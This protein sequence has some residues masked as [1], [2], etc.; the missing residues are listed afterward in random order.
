MSPDNLAKNRIEK[1]KYLQSISET[2]VHTLGSRFKRLTDLLFS[3]AQDLYS[4]RGLKVKPAWIAFL[5]TLKHSESLDIKRLANRRRISHSAA[6]QIIKEMEKAGF[7]TSKVEEKDQRQRKIEITELGTNAIEELVPQLQIIE[8][9]FKEILGEDF[10]IF[11][12]ILERFEYELNE[13][14]LIGRRLSP[15][16][17]IEVVKYEEKFSEALKYLIGSW[18]NKYFSI[19]SRDEALLNNPKKEILENGG[20]I[21]VALHE[22][23]ACGVLILVHHN[24]ETIELSKI[25]ADESL[26]GRG[27]GSALLKHALDYSKSKSYKEVIVETDSS[28]QASIDLF[29][30]FGFRDDTIK[31]HSYDN[32]GDLWFKKTL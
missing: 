19:E 17:N 28:L 26:Y 8:K 10:E 18:L 27:I 6:S 12:N 25:V 29:R 31:S 22:N 3:Q 11:F 21:F 32:R 16:E 5:L 13:K 2:G 30:K 9:T 20:E 1:E 14:P 15:L 4:S 23:E 7:V 24:D